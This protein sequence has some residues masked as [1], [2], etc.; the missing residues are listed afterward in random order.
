EIYN[1]IISVNQAKPQPTKNPKQGP[2]SQYKLSIQ[3]NTSLLKQ[4]PNIP[5]VSE[6][7]LTSSN[8]EETTAT[9]NDMDIDSSTAPSKPQ[10]QQLQ[11]QQKQNKNNNNL[12]IKSHPYHKNNSQIKNYFNK[13]NYLSPTV[14]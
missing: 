7:I 12:K 5:P 14:K 9:N 10:Q 13:L 2:F 3:L 11:T 8:L 6:L 1:E 4:H